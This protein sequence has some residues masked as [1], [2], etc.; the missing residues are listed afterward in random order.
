MLYAVISTEVALDERITALSLLSEL[1]KL[2][3]DTL[4]K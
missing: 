2:N 4:V 3:S 1:P